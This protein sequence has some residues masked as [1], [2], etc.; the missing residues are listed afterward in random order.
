[1]AGYPDGKAAIGFADNVH[2]DVERRSCTVYLDGR[3]RVIAVARS[4]SAQSSAPDGQVSCPASL[5]VESAINIDLPA[6]DRV[7][8]RREQ[9]TDGDILP[10]RCR[11]SPADTDGL[12]VEG[13]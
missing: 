7:A 2:E 5:P 1:M 11:P 12:N 13:C 6:G 8:A 3:G 10:L 9:L 4:A